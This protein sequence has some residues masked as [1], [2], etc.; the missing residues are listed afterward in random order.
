MNAVNTHSDFELRVER[1]IAAP[2]ETVFAFWTEPMNVQKW[3]CP[4]EMAASNVELDLRVGGAWS[5]TMRNVDGSQHTVSGVYRTIEPPR[6]LVFTWKWE[7]VDGLGPE[8]DTELTV[9]LAA[10]P[11]GTRM[12]LHQRNFETV[13]ARDMHT[14]GW[15]LCF[16]KL[17]LQI[18]K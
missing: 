18:A 2:P 1:L 7:G 6:K 16:D 12:V 9:T 14:H 3:L 4:G 15:G 8:R 13:K 11:G 10:A 5:I 17:E